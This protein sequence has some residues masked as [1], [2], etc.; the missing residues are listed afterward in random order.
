MTT[1]A[2]I[3]TRCFRCG[4]NVPHRVLRQYRS[5]TNR[6]KM[7]VACE[8]CGSTHPLLGSLDSVMRERQ[9]PQKPREDRP[10][11]FRSPLGS[12]GRDLGTCW[13]RSAFI[14]RDGEI[15]CLLGSHRRVA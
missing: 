12:W 5:T 14:E 10:D 8:R 4:V 11:L 1:T 13:C 15:Q 3:N 9:I 7:D 6:P 2:V